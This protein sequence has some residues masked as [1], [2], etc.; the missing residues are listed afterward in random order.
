MITNDND[1]MSYYLSTLLNCTLLPYPVIDLILEYNATSTRDPI[2]TI[3][4]TFFKGKIFQWSTHPFDHTQYL[5]E[6]E[7]TI[8]HMT[9]Y[10]LLKLTMSQEINDLLQDMN[11][12]FS[13]EICIKN[14]C[15]YSHSWFKE[16]PYAKDIQVKIKRGDKPYTNNLWHKH[17]LGG[18]VGHIQWINGCRILFN[19]FN[20]NSAHSYQPEEFY[21]I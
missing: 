6:C 1:Y 14:Q 4:L 8:E 19:I 5:L 16:V 12:M 3:C 7:K 21:N 15:T 18:V 13:G 11:Q 2:F 10:Y 9:D 20:I 17:R